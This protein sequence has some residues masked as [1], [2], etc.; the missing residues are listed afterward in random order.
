MW[1]Y[2]TQLT[3]ATCNFHCKWELAE[4]YQPS[5]RGCGGAGSSRSWKMLGPMAPASWVRASER[6]HACEALQEGKVNTS[7]GFKNR[8]SF[9][10][11]LSSPLSLP[12][13]Y[14]PDNPVTHHFSGTIWVYSV[15]LSIHLAPPFIHSCKL[16]HLGRFH[17]THFSKLPPNVLSSLKPS[18]HHLSEV[19]P[20]S[21]ELS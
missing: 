15:R 3:S 5:A 4:T 2:I 16:I 11:S 18:L 14:I 13:P 12:K 10:H 17:P 7:W 20:S 8:S 19:I 21:F 6:E 9:C 1:N